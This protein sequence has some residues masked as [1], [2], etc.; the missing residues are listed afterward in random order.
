M[1]SPPIIEPATTEPATTAPTI[2]DDVLVPDLAVVFCG[3]AAGPKSAREKTPY[4]GPNNKFWPTLKALGLVPG[5][6][7]PQAFR[8]LPRYGIGLTDVAKTQWGVDSKITVTADDVRRLRA[9]IRTAKPRRLAFVGKTAAAHF[10]G[11]ATKDLALGRQA[12]PWDGAAVFVLCSTSAR[13]HPH[14]R[15]ECW[16]A[17]A[18][19]MRRGISRT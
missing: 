6:F 19:D 15:P 2:I 4:I 16:H 14:W 9:A 10:F 7:R 18:A 1:T 11:C 5:D 8:D 17:L 12:E 3:M 13:A